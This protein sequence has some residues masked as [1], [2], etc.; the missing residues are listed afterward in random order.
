M[1][2]F[3]T[4]MPDTVPSTTGRDVRTAGYVVGGVGLAAA[5]IGVAVFGALAKSANDSANRECNNSST[6]P[7]QAG[8][9][10]ANK[11]GVFAT[12]STAL[13]IGGGVL[14]LTGI[15]L[16]VAAPKSPSHATGFFVAPTVDRTGGGAMLGGTF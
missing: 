9:D 7:T 14:L 16:V 1:L 6:C 4:S 5:V 8:V 12:T 2:L 10:D 11:A 13:T 3:A 15:V